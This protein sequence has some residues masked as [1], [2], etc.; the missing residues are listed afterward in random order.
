M[1][2]GWVETD[3]YRAYDQELKKARKKAVLDKSRSLSKTI[4]GDYGTPTFIAAAQRWWIQT[5]LQSMSLKGNDG[6]STARREGTGKDARWF[7]GDRKPREIVNCEANLVHLRPLNIQSE[8]RH[9]HDHL[10]RERV[11]AALFE[12]IP[13]AKGRSKQT[14]QMAYDYL[15]GRL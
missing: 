8:Q 1:R 7:A 10:Q 13:M 2:E 11:K 14:I 5:R 3:A 12:A 15:S 9:A 6:R 4:I